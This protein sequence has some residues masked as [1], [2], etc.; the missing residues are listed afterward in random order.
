MICTSLAVYMPIVYFGADKRLAFLAAIAAAVISYF[1]FAALFGAIDKE[2]MGSL[3]FCEKI[4][5]R[6]K[7]EKK[8]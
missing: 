3:P 6:S 1:F 2:D 5:N 8:E 7:K 4:I